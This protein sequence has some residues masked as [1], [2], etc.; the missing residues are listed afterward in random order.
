M[1]DVYII[2]IVFG[3][4]FTVLCLGIALGERNE[5]IKGMRNI[6]YGDDNLNSKN[7]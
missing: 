4:T 7:R 5:K 2:L 6:Y 1:D 3:Y